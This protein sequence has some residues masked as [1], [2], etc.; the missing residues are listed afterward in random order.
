MEITGKPY[1]NTI[2]RALIQDNCIKNFPGDQ[3]PILL[4]SGSHNSVLHQVGEPQDLSSQNTSM[5][6]SNT[7]QCLCVKWQLS[8]PGRS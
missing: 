1:K 7:R 8:G 3:K 6:Q 5:K 4:I 2:I